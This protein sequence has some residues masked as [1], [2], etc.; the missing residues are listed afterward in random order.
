MEKGLGDPQAEQAYQAFHRAKQADQKVKLGEAYINKYPLDWHIQAAYE[1]LAQTYYSKQDMANFYQLADK[2]IALYPDDVM[3]LAMSGWA[4][5]RAYKPDDPDGDARLDKA[6]K[7]EK[8]ALEVL[9]GLTKP[10]SASDQQFETFK[11][12]ESVTAHSALGLIYFRRGQLEDAAKELLEATNNAASPDP[13]DFLVLGAAYQ[14]LN[15]FKEAAD[16]YNRCAQ[17]AGPLQADCKVSA[18]RTAK[19]A[20]ALAK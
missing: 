16:A 5:P 19:Q 18:D 6:E 15:R 20:A 2:G 3:L 17:I 12:E 11:T 8:H 1:E 13:T 4:I 10:A 9:K 14:N 7:Y